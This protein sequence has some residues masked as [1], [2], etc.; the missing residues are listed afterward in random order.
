MTRIPTN[1]LNDTAGNIYDVLITAAE[2]A[3]GDTNTLN[4]T[5]AEV[6]RV[7]L[8]NFYLT[9]ENI[10]LGAAQIAGIVVGGIAA[11]VI[12]GCMY[13]LWYVRP[14]QKAKKER[15]AKQHEELDMEAI[16]H[17]PFEERQKYL[18]ERKQKVA[19]I[20]KQQEEDK[21]LDARERAARLGR[22]M[23]EWAKE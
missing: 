13:W 20:I 19:D 3:E 6:V 9:S 5:A 7:N 17:L 1:L 23:P 11:L 2:A 10:S 21:K 18:E 16:T 15:I 4:G 14:H 12:A 8:Q 22:P